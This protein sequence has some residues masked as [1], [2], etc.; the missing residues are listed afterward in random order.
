MLW[1]SGLMPLYHDVQKEG[2][3]T[4]WYETLLDPFCSSRTI[5]IE[6][7]AMMAG[8]PA[9]QLQPTSLVGTS[10]DENHK[11]GPC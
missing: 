6:V 10:F 7:A 3:L 8:M 2:P 4:R 5:A 9:G 11:N 1:S